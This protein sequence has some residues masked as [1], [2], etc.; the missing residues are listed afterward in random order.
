MVPT[1]VEV[2]QSMHHGGPFPAT[3]DARFTAVGSDA[4]LRFVRPV[5]FQNCP[6]EWLPTELQSANPLN[7]LRKVNGEWTR[8][9]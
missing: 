4:I 1:G 5:S 7:I 6:E 2:L 9:G 8:I 3:T